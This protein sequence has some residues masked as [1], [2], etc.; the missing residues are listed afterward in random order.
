MQ[1]LWQAG[2]SATRFD[3]LCN[4]LREQGTLLQ[5]GTGDRGR[6]IHRER[7]ESVASSV[8]RTI[9]EE[10]EK[11][12]PRRS[13]P[14]N[15]ILTACRDIARPDLLDAV[16]DH[17]LQTKELVSVGK[18][19][20]PADAQVQ[21]TKRQR[22]TR[23]TILTSIAAGG[24]MPPNTKELAAATGASQPDVETLLNVCVEDG[25]LTRV[26]GSFHYAPENLEQARG[27]CENYLKEHSE[28]TMSQLRDSWGVSR[29]F[30]VPL[31]EYFDS[32]GVTVRKGDIRVAGPKIG[33]PIT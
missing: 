5:L 31:C 13:L 6:W 24:L 11:H 29:K 16:F 19:L 2:I 8:L 15:S 9:R 27:M 14:R 18:N 22:Q 7:L 21:L 30:S 32:I 12:H 33:E 3:D 28:A 10:L 23:D 17:L 20:G 25:F 4:E 1:A 26:G